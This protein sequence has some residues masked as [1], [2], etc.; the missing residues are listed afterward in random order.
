MT[1]PNDFASLFGGDPAGPSQNVKFRQGVIVAFDQNT[2]DNQVL[3]GNAILNDLPILGVGEATLL[4]QGAVV[5]IL[6]VGDEDRAKT[7]FI[8][9]RSVIPNTADATNAITLLNSQIFS[10]FVYPS[11]E[12]TGSSTYTDLAT[13]G[14]L[15][16]VPVGPSGRILVIASAQIQC[17]P[18]AA[19]TTIGDG[20]F[21]VEF[22]GVNTRATNEVTD[23]LVGIQSLTLTVSAGTNTQVLAMSVTTQAV[24]SGLNPGATTIK[25]VYRKAAAGTVN[26]DFHRR[27]LTVFK[28]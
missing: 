16:T 21:D 19:V 11:G 2:L 18:P 3:V 4:V 6:V 13:I 15:V 10:N 23:P 1:G 22:S 25:M 5:G 7:M 20:R 17:G 14:P 12:S 27:T 24:F 9:G 8:L 26:P 28:L